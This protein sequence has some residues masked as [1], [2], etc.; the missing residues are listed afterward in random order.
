MNPFTNSVVSSF[1][2]GVVIASTLAAAFVQL[3]LATR[4]VN[5][6][7]FYVVTGAFI[8]AVALGTWRPRPA[9]SVVLALSY[10]APAAYVIWAGFENYSFEIVWSLPLLGLIVSGRD[11][12]RW[13]L[14]VAWRWPLVTWALVVA[15]SWPF[16]FL[17]ELDFY[18]G[19]L[20]LRGVANTSIGITPWDAV[21][22]VT[23]WTLVHNIG[24]LWFDRLFGWYAGR[25]DEFRSAVL[26][27]L[28]CALAVA[29]AVGAY[30]A[31]VDLRFI[32]PHLWPHMG[33]ASGT[34]GDANTFGM[35]AALWGPAS[36]VLARRWRAPWSSVV[37]VAGVGM[38]ILGVLTSGS[39][40][41]LI[42]LGLSLAAIALEA[43]LAWRRAEAA[44]R[45]SVKKLASALAGG[46]ILV[47][48]VLL[49]ARGSSIT[50]V[51]D[52]GSLGYVPFIG[53]LGI[54]ASMK[55]L[56]WDRYGYG[57]PA[58]EMVKEHPW[59]GTGVGTFHT[60]VHDFAKQL[61]GLDLDPDNA[62]SWFRHNLA[63][64][65][66][67][68]SLPW[69]AWCLVFGASLL[70]PTRGAADRFSTGVLRGALLAFGFASL[71]AMPGQSMPVAL[72]F[73]AVA[74]WFA[75]EKGVAAATPRAW[76]AITWGITLVFV[77]LHAGF[78]LADARGDLRPRN[79]SM[80]FGWNYSYGLGGVERDATGN[81]ERRTSDNLR[82]L[83]VNPVTGKVLKLVAWIDHP[84]GDEKPVHV[85][86]WADSRLVF[87]GDVKRSSAVFLDIP[88]TPGA[89]HMVVESE[90]SRLWRPKDFGRNDLRV[91]GLSIR[92]WVWE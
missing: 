79:R 8:V 11:G 32:N 26:V 62:Q 5:V 88:A 38:A 1:T 42:V 14:P 40:T 81:P 63:E 43:A 34:L 33:R 64:L 90:I 30:Q 22:A 7:L 39:R 44:S 36:V 84:D 66:V 58:I 23:Y 56:L 52:R 3:Y 17:R 80:R 19:I 86:L 45:P 59:A 13:H 77:L 50:S 10:L 61:S 24:L 91:L 4:L 21:T 82:T 78:T 69:L 6:P 29:T 2:K 35:L 28:A 15:A 12:W 70:S 53:D 9:I 73:W 74:F 72:T 71:M 16:V 65:G 48:V 46:F 25:R 92:D 85:R 83:A 89:T 18:I 20:P 87:D 54:G 51:I 37:S 31:F 47:V 57:P 76:P 27:P 41:A 55:D 60:L 68:G 49:V 75:L 67:L